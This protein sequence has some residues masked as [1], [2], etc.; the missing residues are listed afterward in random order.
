MSKALAFILGL[1][2]FSTPASATTYYVSQSTGSDSNTSTQAQSKSTPWQ[3][4]PG[5]RTSHPTYTP[6]AGDTFILMGC[7]DWPSSALPINWTWSGT[8]GSHIVID[9]DVT[10]YNTTNCP[11]GWNRP[12]LDAGGAA[13]NP[14]ECT[15]G[16]NNN[17]N[18]FWT[19]GTVNYV[20]VNWIELTG[21]F[22]AVGTSGTIQCGGRDFFVT[23]GGSSTN[24]QW[25]NSY[26]HNWTHGSGSG[27]IDGNGFSQGCP[28][29]LVDL[30]VMD[31][32]DGS[33]YSGGGMQWPT[34]HSIFVYTSNAIKPHGGGEYGYNNISHLGTGPGGNHPNCIETIGPI[35]GGNSVFWIHDNW[36]HDMPTS[37]NN[38]QCETLQIGNTGE[39]DYV[40]NN[41]WAPDIGG[42]DVAQ[43]P[44]NNQPNVVALYMFNNVWEENDGNGVCMNAT[45][46]TSWTTA[47]VMKNNFC[48]VPNTPNGTTQSQKIMSGSTITSPTTIDFS[49]NIAET[50]S[51]A[52]S[53]GYSH[54]TGF[55]Y[56]PPSGS[57][58]T[59]GAGANLTSTYWPAGYSTNDTTYACVEQTVSGVVESVCPGRTSNAR[60]ASGAWDVGPYQ[61]AAGPP[62]ASITESHTTTAT[63]VRQ[64]VLHFAM[65]E[66]LSESDNVT[67]YA[68]RAVSLLQTLATL[69][70]I[71]EQTGPHISLTE[72]LNLLDSLAEKA[73]HFASVS[74]QISAADTVAE[75]AAHVAG[76]TETNTCRDSISASQQTSG[77]CQGIIVTTT[78][79]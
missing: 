20:Y 52:L 29:C 8:S 59:V 75:Q 74:T 33:H 3:N 67:G 44:Q 72:T 51:T 76:L 53:Q 36:I 57:A 77:T 16:N 22:W 4:L 56:Y 21:Y 2:F 11:S 26:I 15:G 31:N 78:V 35:P 45:N 65:N 6:V 32:T 9:R 7:D 12:K 39:T 66:T 71:Q 49:N 23:V 1:I 19:F 13:I 28:T 50:I 79:H 48:L 47:F 18:A 37:P 10:W 64:V 30:M 46:G 68:G 73:A 54:T 27:D 34:T 69:D 40:W 55:M 42:G 17:I 62:S 38:E 24:V 5:S 14:P 58:I 43:F 70:S 63:A 61:L 60:P 25:V 41:V